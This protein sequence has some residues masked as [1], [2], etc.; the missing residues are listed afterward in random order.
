MGMPIK[1]IAGQRFG[2]LV[3]VS[4]APSRIKPSGEKAIRWNVVCDCGNS[5]E[6]NG[7]GLRNGAIHQCPLC[8][9]KQQANAIKT[10]GGTDT[11]L[12]DV[13]AGMKQRCYNPNMKAYAKYGGRGITI[14]DE[15]LGENGFSNF[16]AWAMTNGYDENAPHGECTIDRIDNDRGYSPDNCQWISMAE[17][18]KNRHAS[19]QPP[20]KPI[21]IDGQK[22]SLR[23]WC[24]IYNMNYSCVSQRVNKWGWD[25]K[26]ALTTP[27]ARNKTN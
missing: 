12:Y 20:R 14:C 11:R 1:N 7:S 22:K 16:R 3:V 24:K 23:Q 25:I 18:N 6:T 17:Q 2:K 4:Q 21:E 10:H 19:V 5:F 9:R 27:S 8:R 26:T 15:W 13:W